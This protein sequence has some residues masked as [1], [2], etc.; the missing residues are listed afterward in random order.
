MLQIRK[1]NYCFMKHVKITMNMVTG[2]EVL[3]YVLSADT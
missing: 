3:L 2:Q 1:I